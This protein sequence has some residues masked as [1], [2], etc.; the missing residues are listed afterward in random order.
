MHLR[1]P[2]TCGVREEW[3]L[4]A[5]SLQID[6]EP[7]EALVNERKMDCIVWKESLG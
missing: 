6:G 5:S 2:L 3:K 7:E 4:Q 1:I